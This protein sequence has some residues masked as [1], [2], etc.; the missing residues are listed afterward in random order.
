MQLLLLL[1]CQPL[2]TEPSTS[3]DAEVR[4]DPDPDDASVPSLSWG[5]GGD[6]NADPDPEPEGVFWTGADGEVRGLTETWSQGSADS[7]VA[8]T[9]PGEGLLEIGPGHWYVQLYV[10]AD[11]VIRGSGA[12]VDAGGSGL[13]LL[14]EQDDTLLRIEDLTLVGGQDG[15]SGAIAC[16]ES[17]LELVGVRVSATEGA[18]GAVY[19]Y[20]CELDIEASGFDVLEGTAVYVEGGSALLRDT[21]FEAV[22]NALHARGGVVWM[23][24]VDVLDSTAVGLRIELDAEVS[25]TGGAFRGNGGNGYGSSFLY[26]GVLDLAGIEVDNEGH[27]VWVIPADLQYEREGVVS[28]RC[29]DK[30]CEDSTGD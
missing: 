21:T 8:F 6:P 22:G 29:D 18:Y 2:P 20:D 9:L 16:R 12:T 11:A 23:H 5:L 3:T 10:V 7:P 27:D 24:E 14:I 17:R 25:W 26:G 19:G 28:L 30:G 1:A 4:P 15:H 13:S